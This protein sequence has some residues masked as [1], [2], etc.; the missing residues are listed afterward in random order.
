M[1]LLGI[2]IYSI[3]N[4]FYIFLIADLFYAL[5]LSFKSGTDV[6]W[7]YDTLKQ[8]KLEE[9]F[10]KVKGNGALI[11]AISLFVSQSAITLFLVKD[12][13]IYFVLM[14]PVTVFILATIFTYNEPKISLIK[15]VKI[16]REFKSHLVD[17]FNVVKKN[18]LLV[19]LFTFLALE[20]IIGSTYYFLL[21]QPYLET[22][23]YPLALFGILWGTT[24]LLT[25]IG[26][27]FS[28][29]IEAVVGKKF[30]IYTAP[31]IIFL[32]ILSLGLIHSLIIA[33]LL[34]LFAQ[35]TIGIYYVVFED[36]IN[37]EISSDKRATILSSKNF[38]RYVAWGSL[39]PLIGFIA[40]KISINYAFLISGLLGL[41]I[42]YLLILFLKPFSHPH[43]T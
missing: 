5:A 12:Y 42:S 21:L 15:D 3:G 40:D 43:S 36:Y 10:K 8:L 38:F 1:S 23:N 41:I 4:S 7:I 37:K 39:G 9:R 29:P 27:Y 34:I 20:S 24:G 22:I 33:L 17:S 2:I 14:I 31:L 16:K 30:I 18:N 28:D 25:G 26:S 35:L 13:R 19:Y 11:N 6:S 32:P